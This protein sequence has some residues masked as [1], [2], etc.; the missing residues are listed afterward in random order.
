ML[1]LSINFQKRFRILMIFFAPRHP[2]SRPL[3]KT[4]S[5]E[6][7][8]KYRKNKNTHGWRFFFAANM[9]N[10]LKEEIICGR[11]FCRIY[12]LRIL[13]KSAKIKKLPTARIYTS[14]STK[15]N[16]ENMLIRK[17]FFH[18][19]QRLGTLHPKIVSSLKVNQYFFRLVSLHF[20]LLIAPINQ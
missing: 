2:R 6:R 4:A 17:N 15:I 3:S 13:S 8:I 9:V 10:N 12:F 19:I 16:M 18:K 7:N 20:V 5:Y 14:F 11:I 1:K